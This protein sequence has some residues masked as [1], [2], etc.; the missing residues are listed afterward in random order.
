ML[1]I[2]ITG[3]LG[4]GKGTI[5]EYLIREEFFVHHSVRA[6]LSQEIIKKGLPLN[7]DTMTWLANELRKKHPPSYIVDR[8]YNEALKEGKDCIIESIRTRGEVESL[9]QKRDFY[10]FAVDA[11][12][13]IRYKRV[14]ARDSET[15]RIS[16]QTFLDNERREM[17]S[18][19]AG[20]Q[21]IAWCMAHADFVFVNNG[22]KEELFVEVKKVMDTL[23]SKN[24]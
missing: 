23:R 9:R 24:G 7:R 6:F 21:N 20:E 12:P 10:L 17:H 15:D 19:G 2:G 22:T 3:T 8:L 4:A 11:D 5:V 1:I 13:A 18:A 16:Y 14:V